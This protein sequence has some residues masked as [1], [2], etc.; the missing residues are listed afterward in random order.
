MQRR[1]VG[2]PISLDKRV[3]LVFV[4]IDVF[5]TVVAVGTF[6]R[7]PIAVQHLFWCLVSVECEQPWGVPA[8]T[9]ANGHVL[10]LVL[11]VKSHVRWFATS[12]ELLIGA[13]AF[14]LADPISWSGGVFP[15]LNCIVEDKAIETSALFY[16]CCLEG[17]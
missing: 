8:L 14:E 13:L 6:R 12:T 5:T 2:V 1:S 4:I 11:L 15:V 10:H 16:T 9:V 17:F 7:L 3:L